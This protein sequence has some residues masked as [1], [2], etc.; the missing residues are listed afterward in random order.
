MSDEMFSSLLTHSCDIY[1]R[2]LDGETIDKWG[3]SN[4]SFT[5]I[6][7]NVDCLFQQTEELIEFSRRGE[8]LYTRTLVFMEIDVNVQNDDI[9]EFEDKKYRVVSIE[10]AAGQ[11]HHIELY[12][13]NLEN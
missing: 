4:E 8:K 2:S 3:A 7:S 9:L 11:G 13:I 10:D 12:V 5:L 1:R 6:T